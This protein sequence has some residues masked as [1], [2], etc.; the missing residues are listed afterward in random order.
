MIITS[1][2]SVVL[3]VLLLST[4]CSTSQPSPPG[5]QKPRFWSVPLRRR[6]S[7][8]G[9]GDDFSSWAMNHRDMLRTKYG[10]SLDK[11]DSGTNLITNQNSDSSYF[12]SLAI[13]TPPVS[14]DVILDTGSADLWVAG[15]DC[16]RGCEGVSST[17]DASSSSTFAN[18][19]TAFSITYGS[20]DA[21]GTLGQDVVQMA[22]F[23][24]PNQV[25]AVCDQ[26]SEGM[27]DEPVS[28]LLGL[29]FQKIA[30]S[31]ASPFWET[32]AAAGAWDEPL[33]AFQL[34]RFMNDSSASD[35][36]P[37]GSFTLGSVNTS[38]YTGDIDYINIPSGT[39]TYWIL[40]LTGLTVQGNSVSLPSGS[41]SYAAIDTG[42][43]LVG[44]PS[45]EIA[46]LFAQIPGSAPG[47]GNFEG[48]YTY[49]CDTDVTVTLSFG[50]KTWTISPADFRLSQVDARSALCVGAFFEI[51]TGGSSPAWIIGDTFLKNVYSVFRYSPPSV[52]FAQL[53]AAAL[54]Q[55][56]VDAAPPVATIGSVAASALAT[57]T[58]SSRAAN[59]AVNSQQPMFS[60]VRVIALMYTFWMFV[61]L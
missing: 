7:L 47:S 42:T 50:G 10:G 6:T 35:L 52:G 16:A 28:G 29:A 49:P 59:S 60:H 17:F 31:G 24:V 11:R 27:L 57:S 2:T 20:G 32:L 41:G 37:G 12:G 14:F 23:S 40:P 46:S 48:Y 43:T 34:S 56:G 4:A 55:N 36:E 21:S 8:R 33:M 61:M 54:G 18:Q 25:F 1:P 58:G 38:L 5:I 26:V 15:K 51:S 9:S 13:G 39:G 44:G 3:S 45:A 30:S 22:G 19:S 53:S